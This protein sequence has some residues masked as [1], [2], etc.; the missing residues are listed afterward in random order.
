MVAAAAD[1]LGYLPGPVSKAN[2]GACAMFGGELFAFAVA[3]TVAVVDVRPSRQPIFSLHAG[4]LSN[5]TTCKNVATME[6]VDLRAT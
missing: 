6:V 1:V 4:P 3:S 2:L 5:V